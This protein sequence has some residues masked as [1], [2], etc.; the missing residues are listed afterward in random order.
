MYLEIEELKEKVIKSQNE[1]IRLDFNSFQKKNTYLIHLISN[2]IVNENKRILTINC[3]SYLV[4][5]AIK[6]L[7]QRDSKNYIDENGNLIK[8]LYKNLTRISNINLEDIK[9][10]SIEKKND[11]NID[12]IIINKIDTIM[13]FEEQKEVI[14]KEL[15]ELSKKLKVVIITINVLDLE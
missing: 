13:E 6:H 3:N 14:F 12:L 10:K 4:D 15:E 5:A 2:L 8:E 7:I 9:N 1:L 11:K